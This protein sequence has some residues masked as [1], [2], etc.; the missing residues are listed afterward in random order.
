MPLACC[1]FAS[2]QAALPRFYCLVACY[3]TSPGVP[4]Q[5]LALKLVALLVGM[6]GHL[7]G[8]GHC[9]GRG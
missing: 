2:S 8:S 9:S 5:L 6:P 7:S 3:A 1:I 4:Q